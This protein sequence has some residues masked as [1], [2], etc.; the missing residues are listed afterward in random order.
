MK[1][2]STSTASLAAAIG[3]GLSAPLFADAPDN[4]IT[5]RTSERASSFYGAPVEQTG[6]PAIS[7]EST[8]QEA[9]SAYGAFR[10]GDSNS[11]YDAVVSPAEG[12][13]QE[14]EPAVNQGA[15]PSLVFSDGEWYSFAGGSWYAMNGGEWH[16]LEATQRYDPTSGVSDSSTTAEAASGVV[17]LR[18]LDGTTW[19]SFENGEWQLWVPVVFSEAPN[20]WVYPR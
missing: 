8:T 18:S 10:S 6:D 19:Y 13:H 2:T 11:A 5:P 17:E 20:E 16:P 12:T 3:L 14:T 1:H 4:P 9:P 7:L 15:A